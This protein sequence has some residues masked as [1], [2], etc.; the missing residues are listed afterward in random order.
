MAP[1]LLHLHCVSQLSLVPVPLALAFVLTLWTLVYPGI[2][3]VMIP[4]LLA[5]KYGFQ[6]TD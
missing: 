6:I 5:S 3:W 4:K 2:S 1:S